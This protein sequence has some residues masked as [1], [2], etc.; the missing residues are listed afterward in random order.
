MQALDQTELTSADL[1]FM[2]LRD[3][4][5]TPSVDS[6]EARKRIQ[7]LG[8]ILQKSG[9]LPSYGYSWYLHGPYS[10][11]L[12]NDLYSIVSNSGYFS[13]RN[14]S[15][16]FVPAVQERLGNLRRILALETIPTQVLEALASM[17]YLGPGREEMLRTLK[18][19]LPPESMEE[20]GRLVQDLQRENLIESR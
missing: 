20:A 5:V 2:A 19:T 6:F 17:L 1:L 16:T 12:T 4:Q 13:T 9:V 18:P 11:E 14:T 10:S 3:L 7:K 8:Y 15:R